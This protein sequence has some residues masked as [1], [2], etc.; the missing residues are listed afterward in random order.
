VW[1]DAKTSVNLADPREQLKNGK[2][3]I[4]FNCEKA[5]CEL[6]SDTAVF[7][8]FF[9]DPGAGNLDSCRLMVEHSKTHTLP[10]AAAANG[11]E[12]CVGDD[13]GN[14]GLMVIQTKSTAMPDLAF[15]T[16]DLTVWRDA[17]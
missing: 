16:A 11:T 13:A 6:T 2:G 4:R 5:G 14:I 3:D 10:L 1:L 7:F 12:I 8:Q 17:A 9:A 15:L